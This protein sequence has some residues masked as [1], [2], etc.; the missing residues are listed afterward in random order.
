MVFLNW[1]AISATRSAALADASAANTAAVCS[2]A[3]DARRIV[4]IIGHRIC[5]VTTQSFGSEAVL[6]RVIEREVFGYYCRN[7]GGN[8]NASTNGRPVVSDR[9]IFSLSLPRGFLDGLSTL[10]RTK[11]HGHRRRNESRWVQRSAVAEH[12]LVERA[13][14]DR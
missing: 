12:Y 2:T 10:H 8:G 9:N 5:R 6:I 7:R 14:A 4:T 3:F 1:L 13:F 11:G